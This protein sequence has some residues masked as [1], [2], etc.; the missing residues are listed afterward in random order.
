MAYSD[1]GK[2]TQAIDHLQLALE[3]E[4]GFVNAKVALGVAQARLKNY[5]KARVTLK[6]AVLEDPNNGYALRNLGAV[7][8]QSGEE[9]DALRY[10]ERAVQLLPKDQ[11]AW[12]GLAQA[13]MGIED[14]EGAD[15][16]LIKVIE[17]QSYNP[18]AQTAR[19]MRSQIAQGRFRAA[20]SGGLRTD[21]VM[22]CLAA[23]QKFAGMTPEQVRNVGFEIATLGMN[24]INV[25]DP[26]SQYHLRTLPGTFTGLQ[27][28]CY[29]YVAFKQFAPE[30]DIGF[31]LSKEYGE[32]KKMS[33][34]AK[35]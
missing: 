34:E 8:L 2:L 20:A 6:E 21:A 14:T 24:G 27:L 12:L 7:L 33:S 28:L 11:Q 5:D 23:I 18:I 10:F 26:D 19:E 32:A 15:D 1:L 17:I 3:I 13:Q 31:D 25:N 4:K 29:E 30:M 16:S 35:T 9:Q 22:Y